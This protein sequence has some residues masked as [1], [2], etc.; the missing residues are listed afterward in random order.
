RCPRRPRCYTKGRSPGSSR[1]QR[2]VQHREERSKRRWQLG[3]C[4]C[5]LPI[6][7]AGISQEG[8]REKATRS[9]AVDFPLTSDDREKTPPHS[10]TEIMLPGWPSRREIPS[11][12]HLLVNVGGRPGKR[13]SGCH[14]SRLLSRTPLSADQ[15][16]SSGLALR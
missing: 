12:N 9:R 13:V 16:P 4:A 8:P 7:A 6:P 11:R 10:S 5:W 2:S 14:L 3:D 15:V 1:D